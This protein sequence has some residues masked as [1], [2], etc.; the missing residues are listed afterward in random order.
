MSNKKSNDKNTGE[1]V[2]YVPFGTKLNFDK[3]NMD[4][5]KTKYEKDRKHFSRDAVKKIVKGNYGNSKD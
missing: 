1:P 2:V 5:P 4:P 3:E